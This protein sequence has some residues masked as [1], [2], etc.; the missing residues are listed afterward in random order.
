MRSGLRIRTKILLGII[1]LILLIGAAVI[2]VIKTTVVRTVER[3]LRER[4]AS[5]ARHAG[6]QCL[7]PILTE[8]LFGLEML[9]HD[10]KNTDRDIAYVFVLDAHNSGI[11][12]HSFD[13]EIP[14]GLKDANLPGEDSAASFQRLVYGQEIVLDVALPLLGGKIGTL[15]MGF[16]EEPIRKSIRSMTDAVLS[17]MFG[18]L[19]LAIV[20]AAIFSREITRPISELTEAAEQAAGGALDQTVTVSTQDE[21]GLL[22]KA[23][24]SMLAARKEMEN[25]L[26]LSEE[27]YRSLVESTDDSIYLVDRDYCY[28]FIN[29]GHRER[30]GFD[31]N[32]YLGKPYADSHSPEETAAFVAMVDS[33]FRSGQSCRQEHRS[34]RDKRFF[35]R[36][37]SPLRDRDGTI[38]AVNVISKYITELKELE[39]QLTSLSLTD[40]LTGLYNRRGFFTLVDQQLKI[41]ARNRETIFMLYADLDNLKTINDSLGHAEG[42][43]ALTDISAIFQETFRESDIIARVGGDEFVMIPVGTSLETLRQMQDRLTQ[44]VASFNSLR[45]RPYAL[46]VS[47]GV[48]VYDPSAPVTVDELLRQADQSMYESKRAKKDA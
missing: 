43:R 26:R 44:R 21:I 25:N 15:R 46:S 10:I 20:L 36:T 12:A 41:A 29:R 1:V 48:A 42:D 45:S 16:S 22:G 31:G 18:V 8:N 34:S 5:L 23:F 40:E 38:I 47:L 9:V 39:E 2:G 6:L 28:L 19:V 37:F 17:V 14:A 7:D 11:L 33:V 3:D 24:N 32:D 27:R 13:R 4:A 30:M 35:L